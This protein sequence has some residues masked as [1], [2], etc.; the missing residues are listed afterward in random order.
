[1]KIIEVKRVETSDST[2]ETAITDA[3]VNQQAKKVCA[4]LINYEC[5]GYAKFEIDE[6]TLKML[7]TSLH[8][9]ES[10]R[11]RKQILNIIY[12]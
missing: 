12:D 10:S 9:I 8:K 11:E 7:E 4:F 3:F 1:M 2:T 6:M 5:H